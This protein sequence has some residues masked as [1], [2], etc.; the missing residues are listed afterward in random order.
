MAKIKRNQAAPVQRGETIDLEI[1]GLAHGGDGVGRYE[2]FAVFVPGAA[3]GDTLRVRVTEV[4]KSYARGEAVKVMAPSPHR[5]E[6]LCPV[7]AEC[8][9]CQMQ[10]IDYQAQLE[11]KRRRVEDALRRIGG[12]GEV[13]VHPVIGMDEA[14][15]YRNKTQLPVGAAD[16]KLTAGAYARGTHRIVDFE[17]CRIQYP[18]NNKVLAAARQVLTQYKIPPYD[19]KSGEGVLRHIIVRTAA[20]TGEAL[21]VLV[22]N[23]PALPQGR[24]IAAAIMAQVPELVGVSQNINP[25]RTNVILGRETKRLAGQATLIDY[26][27]PFSFAISPES[28]FQVNPA[29]TEVLYAKTLEYAGL[30]GRETVIDAYCGIGTISLFL[31]RRAKKVYGIEVVEAAIGDARENARRNGV[32]NAE[33]IA[34]EVETVLPQ[35]YAEGIRADV[36]VVDPPRAGCAESALRVF[37]AMGPERFVYV[38]C[39]PGSLA[40]DLAVMTGLGYTVREVQPVDMFPQ[41]GHVECVVLMSRL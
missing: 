13:T 20:R 36:V 5:T 27:G 7:Y 40:R 33:F 3:P 34:G 41:T 4:K 2:G 39:N 35:L 21:L 22:T 8:G 24:E 30:T 31:A 26:I 9:G 28:F 38:S 18:L 16:G 14:W 17:E 6:P 15:Y 11:Y 29:Q 1:T 37:A 32:E 19:E 10:H 25:D 23:G 12:L